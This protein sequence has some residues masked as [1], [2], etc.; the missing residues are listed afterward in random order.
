[1][2]QPLPLDVQDDELVVKKL[3]FSGFKWLI[4]RKNRKCFT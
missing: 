2:R 4:F 3:L 1:M